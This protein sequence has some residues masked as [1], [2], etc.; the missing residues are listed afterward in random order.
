MLLGAFL[1]SFDW[2]SENIK[3]DILVQINSAVLRAAGK[4]KAESL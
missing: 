4:K 1:R 2:I 3:R